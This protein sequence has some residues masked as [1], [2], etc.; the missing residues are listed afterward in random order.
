MYFFNRPSLMISLVFCE[1]WYTSFKHCVLFCKWLKAVLSIS[2]YLNSFKINKKEISRK[3]LLF[4]TLYLN[5]VLCLLLYITK[6]AALVL[7]LYMA[8]APRLGL[9]LATCDCDRRVF[10][11]N[12]HLTSIL[13]TA[14]Q[15]QFRALFILLQNVLVASKSLRG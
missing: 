8:I 5:P 4:R 10:T 6:L 13:K 1:S 3:K 9:L 15:H 2:W 7:S 11:S 12:S 14:G